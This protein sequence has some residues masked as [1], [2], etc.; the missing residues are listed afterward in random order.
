[1]S[2]KRFERD[3]PIEKMKLQ[4]EWQ[5]LTD[6]DLSVIDGRRE[7]LEGLLQKYYGYEKD[8]AIFEV[9]NWLRQF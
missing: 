5:Q 6:E 1:M 8:K 3:W 9:D 2:W 4:Q 7:R